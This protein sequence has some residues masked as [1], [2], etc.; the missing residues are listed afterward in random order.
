MT[1]NTFELGLHRLANS[2][3]KVHFVIFPVG[4]LSRFSAIYII[5]R[6]NHVICGKSRDAWHASSECVLLEKHLANVVFAA[7]ADLDAAL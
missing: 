4:E 2:S 5:I 7:A 1:L 3:C 6:L